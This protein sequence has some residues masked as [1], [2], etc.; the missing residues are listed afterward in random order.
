M[1]LI[2][3]ITSLLSPGIKSIFP[4]YLQNCW[5][6]IIASISLC[7]LICTVIFQIKINETISNLAL[8]A[9]SIFTA[10]VFTA[11]FTV[12][13]QLSQKIK[14]NENLDDEAS[15][16]YLTTY[17]NF[18]KLFSKQLV[19][20]VLNSLFII[21]LIVICQITSSDIFAQLLTGLLIPLSITFIFL[22][23]AVVSN[24]SKMIEDNLDYSA[25]IIKDKKD[26]L[27][28]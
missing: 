12:P 28:K 3:F 9:L 2:N 16:N 19:S 1:K 7:S 21:V 10:L 18:I 26:S 5:C 23:I 22:I 27:E 17:H 24:I 11:I 20:L 15:V 14:E 25:K 13:N 6:Y 4:K 8:P